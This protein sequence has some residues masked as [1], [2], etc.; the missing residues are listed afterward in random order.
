M[1]VIIYS[2]INI[3]IKCTSVIYTAVKNVFEFQTKTRPNKI[4]QTTRQED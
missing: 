3:V 1:N 2:S 4:I